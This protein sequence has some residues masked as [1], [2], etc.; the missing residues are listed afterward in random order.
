M[1]VMQQ[2][3]QDSRATNRWK[4]RIRVRVEHPIGVI[5]RVFGFTKVCYRGLAKN[6]HRLIVAS[7]LANLFMVSKRLLRCR[8]RSVV[9]DQAY[10]A[11]S[12]RGPHQDGEPP[13]RS[14]FARATALP[15]ALVMT[16]SDVP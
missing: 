9:S 16:Y 7:A 14:P 2:P 15:I 5:K 10:G 8:R 13:R 11:W 1:T 4:S 3:R 12:P 6:R